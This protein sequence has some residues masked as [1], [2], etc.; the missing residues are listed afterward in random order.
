MSEQEEEILL[1]EGK[2]PSSVYSQRKKN[3]RKSWTTV[4]LHFFLPNFWWRDV[5]FS[6]AWKWNKLENCQ[7]FFI[8]PW[9]SLNY[10]NVNNFFGFQ[11]MTN[12]RNLENKLWSNGR[13]EISIRYSSVESFWTWSSL[14]LSN[15]IVR[16][17]KT[18]MGDLPVSGCRDLDPIIVVNII[19]NM[20]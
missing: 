4:F 17:W 13:E 9:E 19:K 8:S 18:N 20:Q 16:S 5:R 15:V 7:N 2:A 1:F 14:N 10:L 3:Y 12:M 11:W 6:M